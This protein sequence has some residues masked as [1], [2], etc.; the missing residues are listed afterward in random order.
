MREPEAISARSG[1]IN[2]FLDELVP[3][4]DAPPAT[5]HGA[6]RHLLF[7]GGKR[8]R[9][10]LA[11]AGCEAVGSDWQLALP[12]AAAV[13]L[14]HTYSLVH[15]D[16]PCMDDDDER[17]GRPTVHKAWDEATALLAGDALQ[18]LAFEVLARETAD[19][20]PERARDALQE[21]ARAASSRGL[22][23]GQ[24]DD[25]AFAAGAPDEVGRL[26]SVHR[27]KTAAL[28]AASIT[29]GAHLGGASA[30][31]IDL[32]AKFGEEVGVA[33]QIAD[34]LLDA[35]DWEPCSMVR[36]LGEAG[37]RNRAQSLLES[38]LA[39]ID[40]FGPEAQALRELACYAVGRPL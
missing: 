3:A 7:P 25:L 31:Q 35:G 5:L 21:V 22:V 18:A 32:L 15:D 10:A 9:P 26:E 40:D 19:L 30:A 38:A 13:E 16:L 4:A 29:S 17:R 28:I 27:R 1:R 2:A 14:I 33:F 23:G 8:L 36:V 6:M 20:A 37:A 12:A 39:R 24:V 34:D 11:F